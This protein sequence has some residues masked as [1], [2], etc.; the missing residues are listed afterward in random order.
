MSTLAVYQGAVVDATGKVIPAALVSVRDSLT[1]F[2]VS[3]YAD[4]A[5]AVPL[6]NPFASDGSGIFVCYTLPARCIVSFSSGAFT[7]TMNDVL[8]GCSYVTVSEVS[9]Y[10]TQALSAGTTHDLAI[11]FGCKY[12]DLAPAGDA[13]LD[14]LIA[15][16]DGQEVTLSNSHATRVI[17]LPDSTGSVAGNQLRLPTA[18]TM[19]YRMAYTFVYSSVAGKWLPKG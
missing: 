3:L 11:P 19:L 8:I 13:T 14:G 7:R 15:S 16:Y 2:Y 4:H 1:G 9:V 17:T 10:A 18:M 5:G 12:L 6:S